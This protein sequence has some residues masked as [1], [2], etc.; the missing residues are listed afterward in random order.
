MEVL[1]HRGSS[2]LTR[3]KRACP[4]VRKRLPRLIPAHAGKTSSSLTVRS[5]PAAHPRSRG[6]NAHDSHM[7]IA[8]LGSS[9]LTRG[10]RNPGVAGG[11][12]DRLIPAHAGKTASGAATRRHGW[13]HPHS[14]GE[15]HSFREGNT[16]TQGSSPLTRGKLGPVLQ[17]GLLERLIPAHAGKTGPTCLESW[18]P[19]AHPRSRGENSIS[20]RSRARMRGSSPLTRGKHVQFCASIVSLR[21]IPAH[22]GKTCQS[23]LRRVGSTA[24]PCSRG[25]NACGEAVTAVSVGSSPL[26]RGKPASPRSSRKKN[27]LIPTHAG[28]T[29]RRGQGHLQG[30]A[31]PRSREENMRTSIFM[32]SAGGS[33]PLTRGKHV[34]I[35]T[36]ST[37]DRLIPAHAGKTRPS[38]P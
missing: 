17:E 18:L 11:P 25:E 32:C 29:P 7:N 8:R 26:T 15:N 37:T 33:S 38:R 34:D 22:A 31:H 20:R 2:P 35:E 3:G 23:R 14:R 6:E 13:A 19:K 28:K 4:C 36:Y 12:R 24:H 21:L 5:S 1:L 9:P 30:A 10:K 27:G 16:R